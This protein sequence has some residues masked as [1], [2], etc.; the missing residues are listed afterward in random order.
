ML[1]IF[2]YE[3]SC[4]YNSETKRCNQKKEHS[5]FVNIIYIQNVVRK[6]ENNIIRVKTI[7]C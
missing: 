7:C 5:T 1:Y 2:I 6:P 3:N 4:K